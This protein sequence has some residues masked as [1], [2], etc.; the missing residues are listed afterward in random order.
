MDFDSK[1]RQIII[2]G[3]GFDSLALSISSSSLESQDYTVHTFEVDFDEV[4]HRKVEAIEKIMDETVPNAIMP[5][6]NSDEERSDFYRRLYNMRFFSLDL[7][8]SDGVDRFI[9]DLVDRGGFNSS[10]PT[11]IISECVLVYMD[12]A[13]STYFCE[14]LL[15]ALPLA[16]SELV[17]WASYDMV[18]PHDPF[19]RMMLKN[20][21]RRGLRVPGFVDYPTLATQEERFL[22]IHSGSDAVER[23]GDQTDT[24]G[25]LTKWQCRSR[26]MLEVYEHAG[27]MDPEERRRIESLERFDEV[28]EW[29]LIMSHYCMTLLTVAPVTGDEGDESVQSAEQLMNY[30]LPP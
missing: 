27:K 28:E 13:A 15:T 9:T 20:I 19:G 6:G 18:H 1:H 8:S 5:K 10:F 16:Q 17:V 25:G 30:I 22:S 2:I 29:K 11:L 4:I 21:Q 7:S 23:K 26:T 3:C 24:R 12:K 14:Q